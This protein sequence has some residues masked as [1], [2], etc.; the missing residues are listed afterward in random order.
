MVAL[1]RKAP[2]HT[3]GHS[4]TP[5]NNSA[6]SAMPAGGQTDE[7]TRCAIAASKPSFAAPRYTAARRASEPT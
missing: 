7:T 4:R 2:I 3:A 6:A 5:H 1:S